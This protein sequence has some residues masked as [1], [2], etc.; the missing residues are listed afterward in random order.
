MRRLI[1]RYSQH[2]GLV[3]G[4]S[5]H[6]LLQKQLKYCCGVEEVVE[7]PEVR[8]R[9]QRSVKVEVEVGVLHLTGGHSVLT[10]F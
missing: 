1:F 3:S 8:L 6:G 9:L 10:I 2:Q 5:Q 4:Q 7:E